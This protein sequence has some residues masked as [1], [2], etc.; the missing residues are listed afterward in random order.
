M[1]AVSL[2]GLH[3]WPAG[4]SVQALEAA[5][6]AEHTLVRS[7]AVAMAVAVATRSGLLWGTKVYMSSPGNTFLTI[8]T[9]LLL[10]DR[11]L[12]CH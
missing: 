9:S 11:H 8:I 4:G 12:I 6:A 5:G 3:T 10:L 1:A 7:V 2:A